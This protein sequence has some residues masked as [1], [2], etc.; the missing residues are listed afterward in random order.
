MDIVF[1]VVSVGDHG[2]VHMVVSIFGTRGYE[3]CH[4]SIGPHALAEGAILISGDGYHLQCSSI[5]KLQHCSN[6]SL[7]FWSTISAVH[8]E[9]LLC[10]VPF[11][12]CSSSN[13]LQGDFP[14][15]RKP[16]RDCTGSQVGISQEMAGAFFPRH[17][18]ESF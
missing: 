17:L 6:G 4:E 9:Q 2:L 15:H 8:F 14:S 3:V 10:H 7:Y 5:W 11:I 1:D 12:S 13:L 18:T 16:S